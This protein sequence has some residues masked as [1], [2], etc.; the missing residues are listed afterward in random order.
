MEQFH[1][2]GLVPPKAISFSL[3]MKKGSGTVK[4][5]RS[6]GQPSGHAPAYSLQSSLFSESPIVMQ[7]SSERVERQQEFPS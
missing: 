7:S 2:Y 3:Q 6:D 4:Q 1:A 5:L